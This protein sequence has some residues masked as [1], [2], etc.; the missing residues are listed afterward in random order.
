MPGKLRAL[1]LIGLAFVTLSVG[2]A[3][4]APKTTRD[5]N[6]EAMHQM[7]RWGDSPGM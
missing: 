2:C 1:L 7:S 5:L 3:Q 4:T 6:A